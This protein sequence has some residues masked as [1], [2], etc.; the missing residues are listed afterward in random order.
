MQTD[1]LDYPAHD[2]LRV[3][4]PQRAA[5][6][7]QPPRKHRQVEHQRGVAEGEVLELDRDVAPSCDCPG[8]GSPPIAL[9]GAILVSLTAKDRRLVIELDDPGNLYNPAAGCN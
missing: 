1:V 4:Q 3:A 8:E 6:D 7:A 2:R 9:R 5:L